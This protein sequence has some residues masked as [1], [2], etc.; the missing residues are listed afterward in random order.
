MDLPGRFQACFSGG[1]QAAVFKSE[2]IRRSHLTERRQ[3]D[4]EH[5][6]AHVSSA[7][8]FLGAARRVRHRTSSVTTL[9]RSVSRPVSTVTLPTT[10]TL[11]WPPRLVSWVPS[12]SKSPCIIVEQKGDRLLSVTDHH[13]PTTAAFIQ[14]QSPHGSTS[15]SFPFFPSP[16]VH[17]FVRFFLRCFRFCAWAPLGCSGGKASHPSTVVPKR[18]QYQIVCYRSSYVFGRCVVSIHSVC[19]SPG[20][21]GENRCRCRDSHGPACQEIELSLPALRPRMRVCLR[22]SVAGDAHG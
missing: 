21:L 22:Q 18:F 15:L 20:G 17:F 13:H 4:G 6:H 9:T 3:T 12:R 16:I 7:R 2:S 5:E 10:S 14:F 8:C 19:S 11:R 1:F